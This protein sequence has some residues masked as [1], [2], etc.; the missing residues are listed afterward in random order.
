MHHAEPIMQNAK[1]LIEADCDERLLAQCWRCFIQTQYRHWVELQVV[2][3]LSAA[4]VSAAMGLI[5]LTKEN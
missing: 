3:T 1:V 2:T 5:W 4:T